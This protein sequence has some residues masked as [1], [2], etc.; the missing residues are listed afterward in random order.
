MPIAGADETWNLTCPLNDLQRLSVSQDRRVFRFARRNTLVDETVIECLM[1][2]R[3]QATY[4]SGYELTLF[5]IERTSSFG[6]LYWRSVVN[7]SVSISESSSPPMRVSEVIRV[8][9]VPTPQDRPTRWILPTALTGVGLLGV[10]SIPIY[11][12]KLRGQICLHCG[13]WLVI[14]NKLCVICILVSCK[15]HPPPPKIYVDNGQPHS[16]KTAAADSDT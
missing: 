15:L 9:S 2:P 14:V 10:M 7:C 6:A 16:D 4:L 3:S 12:G 5:I 8:R 1:P 13:S 11:N